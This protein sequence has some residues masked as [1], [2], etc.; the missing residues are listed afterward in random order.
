M[1]RSNRY[2]AGLIR[3]LLQ[4]PDGK[5]RLAVIDELEIL[6]KDESRRRIDGWTVPDKFEQSVQR[7][8]QEWGE[9]YAAFRERDLPDSEALFYPPRGK[10]AG[11]W[12]V[13][14][15][16]GRRWLERYG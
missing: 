10:S 12:A 16:R 14:P 5:H 13:Y 4:Y 1:A 2:V 11:Y 8:F 3:I 6:L 9:G 7:S 15:D